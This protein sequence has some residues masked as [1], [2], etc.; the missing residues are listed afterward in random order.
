MK[1][2]HNGFIY[3]ATTEKMYLDLASKSARSLR[4]CYGGADITLFTHKSW[5]TFDIKKTF[6]NII[7]NDVPN[8]PRAKLHSL[9][10]TP[11]DKTFYI[12]ADT[13]INSEEISNVFN[14]LKENDLLLTPPVEGIHITKYDEVDFKHHCGVLLY[15]RNC[16]DLFNFWWE[17]YK[18]GTTMDDKTFIEKFDSTKYVY[19]NISMLDQFYF[20]Y[21]LEKK[22]MYK[23]IKV[24][25]FDDPTKWQYIWFMDQ[26]KMKRKDY[27]VYHRMMK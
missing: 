21:I 16:F 23:H 11:Y 12:D 14:E 2:S 24:S 26:T 13:F 3:V 18:D 8:S 9:A 1:K 17:L 15:N 20:W 10:R 25:M 7:T 4:A 5:V 19:N 22:K 6:N 27:V